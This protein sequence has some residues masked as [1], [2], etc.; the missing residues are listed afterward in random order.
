MGGVL[1]SHFPENIVPCPV[2]FLA[3]LRI[4]LPAVKLYHKIG[5]RTVKINDILPDN[6]L[7]VKRV[8]L[9]LLSSQF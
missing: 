8:P 5:L 6:L 7:A 2:L 1:Y 9:Q 3:G 4:V